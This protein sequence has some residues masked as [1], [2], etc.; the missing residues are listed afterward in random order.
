MA[1]EADIAALER[2]VRYLRRECD[3]ALAG[4]DL[5]GA[6]VPPDA[7]SGRRAGFWLHRAPGTGPRPVVFEMHGG[8][9]ALGDARKGDALR[10]RLCEELD[11]HVVGVEYRLAPEHPFPAQL[12][13]ALAT[14]AAVL[15]GDLCEVDPSACVLMGYSAGALLATSCALVAGVRH[16]GER[17]VLGWELSAPLCAAL[18]ER[19]VAASGLALHYP[20]LDASAV[21]DPALERDIDVPNALT[22]A[23]GRWY[24]GP[25]DA[26]LPLV[27]PALAPL[28]A[29]A[30]LPRTVLA[31]VEGDPLLPQAR[32]MFDR[33]CEAGADVTWL[34]VGGMYHGYIEDAADER[35]YLA[36]TMPE[37][38]AARPAS[39]ARVARERVDE[40]L[41]LLLA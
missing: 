10:Q 5:S 28:G 8:G 31:P 30:T 27:S 2:M 29:L 14:M 16:V 24:A 34:P 41:R 19:P 26:R 25:A 4:R 3:R 36:T 33:M 21:P 17:E 20:Y 15:S 18:D 37:T 9:F 40:S 12:E 7:A 32:L 13:D 11:M 1:A 22:A 35:T 38:V 6:W 23:F 39:Y